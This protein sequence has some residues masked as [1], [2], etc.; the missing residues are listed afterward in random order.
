M[1]IAGGI[2]ATKTRLALVSPE[3][4]PHCFAV[5][6]NV[7]SADFASSNKNQARPWVDLTGPDRFPAGVS[8][9]HSPETMSTCP[10]SLQAVRAVRSQNKEVSS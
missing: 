9:S 1:L 7:V 4:G 5:G 2:D 3:A 6:Q 10:A 8:R